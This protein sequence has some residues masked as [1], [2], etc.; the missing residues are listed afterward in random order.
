MFICLQGNLF[1]NYLCIRLS[2]V[3]SLFQFIIMYKKILYSLLANIILLFCH[4]TMVS[5]QRFEIIPFSG[6]QTSARIEAYQGS[7]RIT[8][9]LNYGA[10]LDFKFSEGYKIEISYSR[11][12][13]DLTYVLD[14]NMQPLCD[15]T[16][17]YISIGGLFEINPRERIVPFVKFAIGRTYYH[18]IAD[19]I[20]T[21]HVMH[22]DISSGVKYFVSEHI[23]FRFQA[24]LLLPVFIDGTYFEEATP[25]PGQGIKTE[26]SGVQGD[27]TVGVIF[28]F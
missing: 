7:L 3:L 2:P 24:S 15:L 26:I 10:A 17:Q 1:N 22:F 28:K 4:L 12:A 6:Y 8:D 5:A 18:P 9:A 23:G 20:A 16:V 27:F 25:P 19:T 11:M 14:N 21:E 13:S